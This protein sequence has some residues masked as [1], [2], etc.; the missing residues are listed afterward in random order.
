MCNIMIFD[1]GRLKC[2][3]DLLMKKYR[4]IS[5]SSGASVSQRDVVTF[6]AHFNA[7]IVTLHSQDTA[8]HKSCV[9]PVKHFIRVLMRCSNMRFCLSKPVKKLSFKS[10]CVIQLVMS[11]MKANI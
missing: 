11:K 3:H 4:T 10:Y 9:L 6:T 2:L 5:C 1:R 8:L 7:E